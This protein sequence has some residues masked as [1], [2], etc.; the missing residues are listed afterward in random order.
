MTMH[1]TQA[2]V[3]TFLT[4]NSSF[5][6]GLKP[7]DAVKLPTAQILYILEKKLGERFYAAISPDKTFE[8]PLST[9]GIQ[10]THW[11]KS[12]NMVGVNVR[13]VQSFWNVVKYALTLPKAQQIVHL[14]PIWEPGVVASLY[15][16]A[17]WNIN[18]E[19]FSEELYR[20][21]PHLDTIEKQ[22]KVCINI[23]H[24]LGKVV[25]MDVIPHTDRYSEIVL[26]NPSHFE[27]L[28]RIDNQI[29]RH[30]NQL[31]ETVENC[32]YDYLS[33]RTHHKIPPTARAFFSNDIS[34]N[35]RLKILFGEKWDYGGRLL[36]REGLIQWLYEHHFE[37]VP[38]TMGPPY[39]GLKVSDTEG[40]K[41]VDERGRVWRD[42]E[43]TEPQEFS[44]VFGPLTRYKLYDNKDDNA[45]WEIDFSQPLTKTF[46]YVAAHYAEV[47]R[48]FNFDFMRGDM[49]HVQMRPEG[50]P[51]ENSQHYDIL[52]YVKNYIIAKNNVPYFANFA[53]TFL[54]PPNLMA[55]GDEIDHL[56]QADAEATLGD[57]QSMV[58]GSPRFMGEFRRYLDTQAMRSL[59]PCFTMMTGD[60]D[61]PR[62]DEF[63]LKGNELRLFT[64][65]FLTNTPSYMGLGFEQR[66][67]HPTPAPNEH[68]TKLYVFHLEK[69][70]N[71]TSGAFVWGQNAALFERLNKIR[72]LS[73]QL[74]VQIKD[75]PVQ[76]LQL[77]DPTGASK[78]AAWKVGHWL[79][80]INMDVENAAKNIAISAPKIAD[81]PPQ[82]Y[83]SKTHPK[84]IFS[85]SENTHKNL[86]INELGA[87]LN[88]L[89]AGGGCVFE[90]L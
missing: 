11:L 64:G 12:A 65:L 71:A 50:V 85:I 58:V 79:F 62:F 81:T 80:F 75:Q 34:E 43:I 16:M 78:I 32:I 29:V 25:G 24:A 17:S 56:E 68:Y 51:V 26:A 14:L 28:Q 60:K 61:D 73:D 37:T 5:I 4:G 87:F 27:W 82:Y 49:A 22:L 18:P 72:V 8:S 63:Y 45:R 1:L 3:S 15:G 89:E 13:T 48:T 6:A 70:K 66:D 90:C 33:V 19:F 59:T 21:Y 42:Y 2:Q 55:F 41:I 47:Q 52:A 88:E 76:W 77:P 38:A 7:S 67:P 53:E 23:L 74:Y 39:R 9:K 36:R 69:G 86:I 57:L 44:R 83:G 30:D 31:Y 10:T 84:L 54:A 40:G 46:D 20:A 35:E